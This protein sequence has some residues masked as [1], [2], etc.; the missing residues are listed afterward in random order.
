MTYHGKS[1]EELIAEI[2]GLQG[3]LEIIRSN[4]ERVWDDAKQDFVWIKTMTEAE[5][6]QYAG[7]ALIGSLRRMGS[8]P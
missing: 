4:E 2:E 7:K 3:I 8:N 5:V 1:K 6:M